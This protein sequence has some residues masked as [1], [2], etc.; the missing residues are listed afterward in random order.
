MLFIFILGKGYDDHMSCF[1]CNLSLSCW[2]DDDDPWVEH[3]NWSP[4]CYYVL[5][6]RGK[7]FVQKICKSKKE[8]TIVKQKVMYNSFYHF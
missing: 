6:N 8:K 2:E 1:S 5:L 3:A 4:N 7:A